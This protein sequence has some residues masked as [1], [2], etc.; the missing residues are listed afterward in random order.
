MD[1]GSALKGAAN[2]ENAKA[3]QNFIVDPENAAM[4]SKF[5]RYDK[6]IMGSHAF[7]DADFA[8]APE[9][10][11]PAGSPAPEF[12]PPCSHEVTEIHNK[13]W[14]KLED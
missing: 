11:P 3:F 12:F 1:K 7:L 10:N 4:I 5:A 8:N 6:G 2:V 13:I 14:T 9:I